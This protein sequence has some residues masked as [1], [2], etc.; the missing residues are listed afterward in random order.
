VAGRKQHYIPQHLLRGFEASRTGK[1][2]QVVVYKKGIAPYTSSTE[3]V[4]AQ[5]DFYSEPGDGETDTLDDV[6][7][8]FEREQFNPIL[9]E[10]RAIGDGPVD[11]ERAAT[12]VVHLTVRAAYLRGSFAQLAQRLMARFGAILADPKETR[13]YIGIDSTL[14]DS[15]LSQG[16]DEVF[17]TL[18]A[19][20]L[21]ADSREILERIARFRVREKFEELMPSSLPLM[22]EQLRRL[23][24]AM[25]RIIDRGHSSALERSLVPKSRVDTLL[26]LEWRVVQA[27]EPHHFVLPDC[28]AIA[29]DRSGDAH[30]YAM[31]SDNDIE[32]VALPITSTQLLI[33][34]IDDGDLDL[35]SLNKVFAKCS[36]EFFVSSR[37]DAALEKVTSQ[38]GLSLTSM[39]TA[40]IEEDQPRR[41]P[42]GSSIEQSKVGVHAKV[43]VD[44]P[45]D[46][47]QPEVLVGTIQDLC[48]ER[49]VESVTI[50]SIVVAR[51]VAAEISKLH[52]RAL[53]HYEI[54]CATLG[55]VEVL[56]SSSGPRL[57]VIVPAQL[58]ELLR[59]P[60]ASPERVAAAYC[61]IHLL[62]RAGYMHSWLTRYAPLGESRVFTGRERLAIE[63]ASRFAGDYFGA[64]LAAPGFPTTHL[65]PAD[66]QTSQVIAACV[67]ALASAA[68]NF[69]SHMN[70]DLLLSNIYPAT[71]MLLRTAAASC[72]VHGCTGRPLSQAM[73]PG[74]D[75]R[76]HGLWDWVRLLDDDLRRHVEASQKESVSLDEILV[77][78]TH[79]ERVLWQFGVLLTDGPNGQIKV[80]VSNDDQLAELRQLLRA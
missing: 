11:A 79:V 55:T 66:A 21:P 28:A 70:A 71:D 68:R 24:E 77:L 45:P 22:Q 41:E 69:H 4:A 3:G 51:D 78:S 9:D 10:L 12:A 27:D 2:A 59:L 60:Y 29:R 23:R 42:S 67:E 8:R 61:V 72:A 18:S 56:P 33:G 40:L 76:Q 30:P 14:P 17:E 6:I 35:T 13:E 34:S 62:G 50:E 31:C 1:K 20:G 32:L 80:I 44:V 25:P 26:R 46:I 36:L 37:S 65:E 57:R 48:S 7:T 39:T 49:G 74:A 64:R 15:M 54:Q 58:A 63:L 5:R 73:P 52:G 53:S 43:R 47:D 38:I 19:A 75:L 16:I